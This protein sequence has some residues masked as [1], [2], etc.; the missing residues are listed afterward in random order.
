MTASWHYT[1]LRLL[2]FN[3]STASHPPDIDVAVQKAKGACG[4]DKQFCYAIGQFQEKYFFCHPLRSTNTD[5]RLYVLPA[6]DNA[7]CQIFSPNG[8]IYLIIS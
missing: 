7:A 4:G 3:I 2:Y 1:V 6:G 8:R 5:K